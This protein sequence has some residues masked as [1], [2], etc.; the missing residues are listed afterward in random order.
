MLISPSQFL[1]LPQHNEIFVEPAA[2][3]WNAK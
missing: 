2:E 3:V 1:L